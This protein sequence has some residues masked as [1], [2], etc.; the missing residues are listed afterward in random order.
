MFKLDKLLGVAALVAGMGFGLAQPAAAAPITVSVVG[1]P[2]AVTAGD[3]FSVDIVV[4]GITTEIIAAWDI[5]VAFDGA[6]LTNNVINFAS[7]LLMANN[8]NDV[9]FDVVFG[10]DQ[11]DA[12]AVSL[13]GDAEIAALQCAPDCGPTFTLATLSFTAL[14]DG[15]PLIELV[16][17]GRANDIKGA[18]NE[19]L[20]PPVNI[21]EP[22]SMALVGLALAGLAARRRLSAAQR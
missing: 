3:N 10:A 11:T 14:A 17:W 18:N 1:T 20:F 16:N 6:L 21:P 19:Q 9:I 22:A 15:A 5:D 13:A 8:I 2:A 4:G 12:F 7:V